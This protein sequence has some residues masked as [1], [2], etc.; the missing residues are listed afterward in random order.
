MMGGHQSVDGNEN[1]VEC[2]EDD[3][4]ES[5]PPAPLKSAKSDGPSYYDALSNELGPYIP[6]ASLGMAL[7]AENRINVRSQSTKSS[8]LLIFI[9]QI[10]TFS[11]YLCVDTVAM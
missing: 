6:H 8:I 11:S 3:E 10:A 5:L 4:I 9:N 2:N 7:F 1:G